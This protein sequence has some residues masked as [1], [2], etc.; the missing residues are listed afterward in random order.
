M[1]KSIELDT[2]P[3]S[4]TPLIDVVPLLEDNN[5]QAPIEKPQHRRTKSKKQRRKRSIVVSEPLQDYAVQ[6]NPFDTVENVGMPL[7]FLSSNV[8]DENDVHDID[9]SS[10]YTKYVEAVLADETCFCQISENVF[11]VNGWDIKRECNNAHLL[12]HNHLFS[13]NPCFLEFMVSRSVN[14]NWNGHCYC[15]HVPPC[16]G[17]RKMLP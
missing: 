11:V 2:P 9:N 4:P 10:K 7:E 16:K 6:D 12:I 8:Q 13:P 1:Y 17:V 5:L 14:K 15:L 3:P